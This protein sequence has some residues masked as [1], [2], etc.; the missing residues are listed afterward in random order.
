MN[1]SSA[2]LNPPSIRVGVNKYVTNDIYKNAD[3]VFTSIKLNPLI[4]R[5]PPKAYYY[6]DIG[7]L[8]YISKH[9]LTKKIDQKY[10]YLTLRK[11]V[12]EANEKRK[13]LRAIL[14][15]NP[16]LPFSV[17][18]K[19]LIVDLLDSMS[20]WWR[21]ARTCW[22][23]T[24]S[25]P[26]LFF[27]LGLCFLAAIVRIITIAL[28]ICNCCCRRS[29]GSK[30]TKHEIQWINEQMEQ[31]DNLDTVAIETAMAVELAKV[32]AEIKKR[33]GV[34][35]AAI[36]LQNTRSLIIH[37]WYDFWSIEGIREQVVW[38]EFSGI[39]SQHFGLTSLDV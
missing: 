21:N 5:S 1:L 33:V 24:C 25:I 17:Y 38:L 27:Y 19:F 3:H 29:N 15:K 6:L 35:A 22:R 30:I 18:G 28:N 7:H 10:V 23:Y 36:K 11:L 26:W 31:N 16:H 2:Q 34:P 37:R 32:S 9:I 8:K 4:A 12:D 14:R 39:N 20:S 13:R